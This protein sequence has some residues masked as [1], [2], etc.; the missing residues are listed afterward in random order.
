MT[1]D[2]RSRRLEHFGRFVESTRSRCVECLE[3]PLLG[4]ADL[5]QIY[6][7]VQGD[8]G[9]FI[10]SRYGATICNSLTEQH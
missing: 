5:V 1:N 6:N 9:R 2:W 7:F 4:S 10:S 3:H 8:V